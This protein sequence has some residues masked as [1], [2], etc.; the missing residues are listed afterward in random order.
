M[1]R[2]YQ[3]AAAL[4]QERSDHSA[5]DHKGRAPLAHHPMISTHG[6]N[7]VTLDLTRFQMARVLGTDT[8]STW[9]TYEAG[10]QRIPA[11]QALKLY[12][13]AILLEWIYDGRMSSLHPHICEKNPQLGS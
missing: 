6:T 10:L 5:H 9:G 1:A 8:T 2:E 3:S 7:P 13:C 4:I 11:D 12:A